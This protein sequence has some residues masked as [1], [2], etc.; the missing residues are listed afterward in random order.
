MLSARAK[1]AEVADKVK[2]EIGKAGEVL[3]AAI[4][5]AA[6]ALLVAIAALVIGMRRAD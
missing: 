4:V 2:T 3:T 6:A 5:L 1:A